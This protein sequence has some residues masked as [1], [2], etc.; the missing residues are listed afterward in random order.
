M[1]ISN[2][3]IQVLGNIILPHGLLII[4]ANLQIT[5]YFSFLIM[6][7]ELTPTWLTPSPIHIT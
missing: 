4:F 6:P 2:L 1:V 5:S 3:Q 7:M